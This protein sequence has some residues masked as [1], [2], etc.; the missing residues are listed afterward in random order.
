MLSLLNMYCCQA[1]NTFNFLLDSNV[2]KKNEKLS[3]T[4]ITVYHNKGIGIR[5]DW[6]L[7]C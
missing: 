2:P 4:I 1:L 5:N 3:L 6:R 7:I